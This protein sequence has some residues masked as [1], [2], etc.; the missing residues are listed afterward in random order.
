MTKVLRMVAMAVLLAF[1]VPGVAAASPTWLAPVDVSATG[2]AAFSPQVTLDAQGNATAVWQRSNGPNTI[3]QSAT[4]PAGGAW[5]APDDLSATGQNAA[6]PQFT[7]DAQGNATA[8]WQRANGNLFVQSATRPAG[9]TWSAPVDLSVTGGDASGPQVAVDAQGIATAVWQRSASNSIVQSATLRAD[10]TWSPPV[11]LSAAGHDASG[12]QVA[13]DAQGNATAIWYGYDGSNL[14]VQSATQPAGQPWSTPV[15]L[16]ATGQSASDPQVT[17]DGQGNA[18]AVWHRSNGT[19]DI[20]QSATRPTGGPWSAPV[21]LSGAG[22]NASAPQVALD[23]QGTATAVWYRY[24]GS[25]NIVQSATRPAGGPWSVPVDLSGAGQNASAPHVALDAQGSAT[26][27]WYRYDGSNN[28]VQSARRPAGGPWSAPVDRSGAGQS[29]QGPQVAVDGQGSATAVWSRSNGSNY[30]VQSAVLDA[31]G[32]VLSSL[33]IPSSAVVGQPAAFSVSPLDTWSALGGTTWSFGD[34]TTA[35]GTAVTHAYASAGAVT[36]TVT[37][38][39]ALGNPTTATGALTVAPAPGGPT[40]GP[41]PGPGPA[42]A[43][44]SNAFTF[45]AAK[46]KKTKLTLTAVLPGP[47]TLVSAA[48]FKAGRKTVTFAT[49]RTAVRKGKTTVSLTPATKAKAALKKLK[50]KKVKV[51][52]TLTFTPTG[53]TAAKKTKAVTVRP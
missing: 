31:S 5:S 20:V 18:T 33:Q 26:A 32:P 21:D 53:G 43:K 47:G 9:G 19:N 2:H 48:T 3:V 24:D 35:I 13:V 46:V 1:A 7:V 51:T 12:S 15:D 36:V 23:A 16:S 6:T 11:D 37:A 25:N 4:R 38:T 39:D 42:K 52:V 27:V 40:P 17:L 29:V 34:G 10:G 30:I 14:I 28:I 50:A 8:V 45:T 44:P 22:Q 49:K 41:T